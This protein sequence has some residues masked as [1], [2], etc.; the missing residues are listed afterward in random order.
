MAPREDVPAL[1]RRLPDRTASA[2]ATSFRP[3]ITFRQPNSVR[4]G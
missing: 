3:A 2:R 1:M 4:N